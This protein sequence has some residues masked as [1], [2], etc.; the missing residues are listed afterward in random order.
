MLVIVQNIALLSHAFSRNPLR[1]KVRV[2]VS[3]KKLLNSWPETDII[4]SRII[5]SKRALKLRLVVKAKRWPGAVG[6][7][8]GNT[9]FLELL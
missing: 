9:Y 6:V 4:L 7:N 8:I 1:I 5:L 3:T 2:D